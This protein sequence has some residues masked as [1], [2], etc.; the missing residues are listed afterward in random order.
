MV[1][2][3]HLIFLY[4]AILK[5]FLSKRTKLAIFLPFFDKKKQFFRQ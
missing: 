5:F 2:Y 4:D 3:N 1:G